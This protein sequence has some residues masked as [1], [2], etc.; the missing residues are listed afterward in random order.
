MEQEVISY[1]GHEFIANPMP[2]VGFKYICKT[3]GHTT[4]LLKMIIEYDRPILTCNEEMIKNL[5][6]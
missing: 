1:Y 2:R 5:L 4:S 3:C 6:E